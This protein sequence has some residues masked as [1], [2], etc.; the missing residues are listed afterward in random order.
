MRLPKDH[1]DEQTLVLEMLFRNTTADSI[2]LGENSVTDQGNRILSGGTGAGR[3]AVSSRRSLVPEA[4]HRP[5]VRRTR[6][7][8]RVRRVREIQRANA[9][10]PAI[11]LSEVEGTVVGTNPHAADFLAMAKSLRQ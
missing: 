7:H 5:V 1:A 3:L 9:G 4:P 2:S 11:G 8:V 10:S 6:R